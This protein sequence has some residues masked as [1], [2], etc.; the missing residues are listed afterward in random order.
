MAG[1]LLVTHQDVADLLRIEERIVDGENRSA[2]DTEYD[3]DTEFLERADD[4]LRTADALGRDGVLA[5]GVLTD[6]AKC[7]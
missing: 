6:R 4:R 2:G 1:T 5:S 3:V 7:A